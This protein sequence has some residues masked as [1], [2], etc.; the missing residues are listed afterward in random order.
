M[1]WEEKQT[2]KEMKQLDA[3]QKG[4]W[5]KLSDFDF[6][7][8]IF[9]SHAFCVQQ[10]YLEIF[11]KCH[12]QRYLCTV[13]SDKVSACH[14]EKQNARPSFKIAPKLGEVI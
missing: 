7:K 2:R 14:R 8:T 11:K 4:R 12:G 9:P 5:S 6:R 3:N 1:T 10:K 13:C